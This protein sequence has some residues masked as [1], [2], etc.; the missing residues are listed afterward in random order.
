MVGMRA[1]ERGVAGPAIFC[2]LR[3]AIS[4]TMIFIALYSRM[5]DIMPKDKM[6]M[7]GAIAT[8]K[9]R[10]YTIGPLLA[11]GLIGVISIKSTFLLA[12]GAFILLLLIA[13]LLHD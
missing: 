1:E 9:D 10:G 4:Y 5:S 11:G 12:G 8:F 6:E 2:C 7:T 13:F 3:C